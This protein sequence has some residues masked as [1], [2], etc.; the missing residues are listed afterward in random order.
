MKKE[1]YD[2]MSDARRTIKELIWR[3]RCGGEIG[4]EQILVTIAV[5]YS[6]GEVLSTAEGG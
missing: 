2:F 5:Y 3:A 4:S 1:T 6:T